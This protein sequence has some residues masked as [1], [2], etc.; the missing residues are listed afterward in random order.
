MNTVA[1][2]ETMLFIS[3]NSWFQPGL[4]NRHQKVLNGGAGA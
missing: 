4:W 1:F 3:R 2:A